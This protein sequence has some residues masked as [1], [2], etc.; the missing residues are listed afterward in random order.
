ME[1]SSYQT[2]DVSDIA[3][4]VSAALVGDLTEALKIDDTGISGGAADDQL[5]LVLHSQT[6]HLVVVNVTLLID[7][8]ADDVEE[9]A[10]EVD[11]AAVGQ[12]TTVGQLHAHHGIAGLAQGQLHGHV[13]LGAGMGL[14][15]G[16]GAAKDLLGTIDS[17]A[18]HHVHVFTATVITVTGITFCVLVGQGVAGSQLNSAAGKVF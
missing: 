6:L 7:A 16:V 18:L 12:V 17:D 4:E 11:R 8:V 2:S 5:G 1:A 3:H 10:G 13:G 15:V 9:M 14:N